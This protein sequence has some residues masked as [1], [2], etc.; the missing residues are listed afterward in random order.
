MLTRELCRAK[1]RSRISGGG[2][3]VIEQAKG[4]PYLL[5]D[6]SRERLEEAVLGQACTTYCG[7]DGSGGDEA[8]LVDEVLHVVIDQERGIKD[9]PSTWVEP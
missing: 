2:S 9:L 8:L 3:I 1:V 6:E 7:V 4:L 5:R